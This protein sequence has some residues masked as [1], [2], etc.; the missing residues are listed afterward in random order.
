[1]KSAS[2]K[3]ARSIA[4]AAATRPRNRWLPGL[5]RSPPTRAGRRRP[6]ISVCW[7]L[8]TARVSRRLVKYLFSL[9]VQ[10]DTCEVPAGTS[11]R[12]GSAVTSSVVPLA[13]RLA[14]SGSEA[15]VS[16]AP[17]PWSL[18]GC[19]V[20]ERCCLLRARV[21]CPVNGRCTPFRDPPPA[22]VAGALLR[23]SSPSL[24]S[25]ASVAQG[26]RLTPCSPAGSAG[27]RSGHPDIN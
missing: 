17:A 22:Q 12:G 1:M 3:H 25:V 8:P 13:R 7:L 5:T 9:P 23:N 26:H 19:P 20:S 14:V 11:L 16:S 6:F 27:R 24:W 2:S 21:C 10:S 15:N 4:E 18:P